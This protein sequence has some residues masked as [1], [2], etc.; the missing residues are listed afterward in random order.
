MGLTLAQALRFLTASRFTV[1]ENGC[2]IWNGCRFKS[3]YGQDGYGQ[4]WLN[5]RN[6]YAHVVMYEAAN[7]PIPDGLEPDHL[8][9][10]PPCFNPDHLEPVTH[11]VNML[12]GNSIQAVNARKTVCKRGHPLAV[13]A[14]KPGWRHC[15]T[16][17]R[18]R[19]RR[20]AFDH[21]QPRA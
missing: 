20:W 18:A 9:R 6:R 12:R 10:T 11:N 1:T 15:P 21:Y 14:S 7:G 19:K 16:C 17:D 3:R 4:F 5:G 8:C 13:I 2:W